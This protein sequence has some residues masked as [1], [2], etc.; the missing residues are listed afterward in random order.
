MVDVAAKISGIAIEHQRAQEA[1]RHSEERNRAIL[2]AI[3]DLMFILSANGVY[4]D[5]YA[6]DPSVLLVPPDDFLGKTVSD[7]LP[8]EVAG[9]I[10]DAIARTLASGEP[11]KIE[12]SLEPGHVVQFYEAFV[13]RFDGDKILSIVRNI[14]DRRRA[15]IDAAIQRRE[16]AHLSRVTTLGEL[17]GA[18]AHELS[19]PMSAILINA[20]AARRLLSREPVD[21]IE[22][23]ATLEDIIANDKRAGTVIERLRALLKKGDGT[24]E[25]L[26]LNEVVKDMLA[27]INS[28]LLA[29]RVSLRTH[30]PS[31]PLPVH[32]D[33][34]QLQ[35]VLLNLVLNA[36]ESMSVVDVDERVL[37]VTT[38]IENGFA[39][40]SVADRGIGIPDDQLTAVFEPFVTFRERGLGLGLAI[41]RSIVVAHGGQI[42]AR[43]NSDRGA[44]FTCGLPLRR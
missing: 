31:S 6:Q 13:V 29:R 41:S 34:V 16:L 21:L 9:P 28:D 15:E 2:R 23:R 22:L 26:D 25:P 24:F 39:S 40:M 42:A 11:E 10:M 30:V 36:C 38:G 35:Q 7:V 3:P 5:Y 14:T 20:Q 17:S 27:L 44:T 19:Q 43:N 37:T 32:G 33:R 4:V 8:P 18:L 1:L 12:F